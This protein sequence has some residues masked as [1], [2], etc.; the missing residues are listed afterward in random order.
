M[1]ILICFYISINGF[2]TLSEMG[3]NTKPKLWDIWMHVL[4]PLRYL[5]LVL[6]SKVK[7]TLILVCLSL[8]QLIYA[9]TAWKLSK[10][11]VFSDPYFDTFHAVLVVVNIRTNL[12]L[13]AAGLSKYVWIY[14]KLLLPGTDYSPLDESQILWYQFGSKTCYIL[15]VSKFCVEKISSLC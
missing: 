6:Y 3:Y 5:C 11:G 10:C 4:A 13:L 2:I 9:C 7:W 8:C 14:I 1:F 12:R 15:K